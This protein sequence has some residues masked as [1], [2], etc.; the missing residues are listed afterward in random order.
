MY[1]N[2]RAILWLVA[3]GRITP[4]EAER[5]LA[6]CSSDGEIWWLL[7]GCALC[8]GLVHLHALPG[9]Q[10]HALAGLVHLF[11]PA[12][13]GWTHAFNYAIAQVATLS[14]GNQ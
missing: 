9:L 10:P 7:A 5:L 8:A 6:A 12:I 3:Q 11:R 4:A 1:S 14:G 2:H 13:N